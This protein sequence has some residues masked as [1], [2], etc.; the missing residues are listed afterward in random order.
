MNISIQVD[1]SYAYD[2]SIKKAIIKN[3]EN[4]FGDSMSAKDLKSI[5]I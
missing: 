2:S 1:N 5:R 4:S 3:R